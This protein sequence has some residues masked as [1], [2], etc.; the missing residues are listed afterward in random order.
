MIKKVIVL[1]LAGLLLGGCSR[2]ADLAS[3]NLSTAADQFE[4]V[5]WR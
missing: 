5:V 4:G 3:E 2:E 1:V